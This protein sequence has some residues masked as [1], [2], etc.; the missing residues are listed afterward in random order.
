M[1]APT[2]V[3]NAGKGRAT[4]R[5]HDNQ[6]PASTALL[7]LLSSF[8]NLSAVSSLANA[9][10]LRQSQYFVY[11]F[12]S[13]RVTLACRLAATSNYDDAADG[14]DDNDNDEVLD[15]ESSDVAQT[16]DDESDDDNPNGDELNDDALLFR[17]CEYRLAVYDDDD[18]IDNRDDY[19]IAEVVDVSPPFDLVRRS[20][21]NGDDT[22]AKPGIF[23]DDDDRV[24]IDAADDDNSDALCF[25]HHTSSLSRHVFIVNPSKYFSLLAFLF[26]MSCHLLLQILMMTTT[27]LMTM[28][29]MLPTMTL[30]LLLLCRHPLIHSHPLSAAVSYTLCHP[31]YYFVMEHSPSSCS[32]PD[33]KRP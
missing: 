9:A 32:N 30:T 19:Y 13:M 27:A 8:V 11:L 2:R 28:M 33:S 20:V 23:D 21:D 16:D 1:T 6:A 29:R 10:A 14:Y 7:T 22:A 26:R 5:T 25:H 18:A 4:F 12:Y 17:F 3:S 31:I 24:D 15:C